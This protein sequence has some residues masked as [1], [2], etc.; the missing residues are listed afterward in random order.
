V[1]SIESLYKLRTGRLVSL[2][3]HELVDCDHTPP[4]SGCAGGSPASAMWWVDLNGGLTTAWEYPYES[5]QGQC[6]RGRISVAAAIA[7]PRWSAPWRGS[8]SW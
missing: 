8:W 5:K 3:E 2:S 1:A 7:R 6:R 4:D